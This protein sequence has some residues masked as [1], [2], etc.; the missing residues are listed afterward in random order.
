[1]KTAK[2]QNSRRDSIVQ[3]REDRDDK[4]VLTVGHMQ[5]PFIKRLGHLSA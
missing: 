5:G 2:T 3:N 1:M 4:Y